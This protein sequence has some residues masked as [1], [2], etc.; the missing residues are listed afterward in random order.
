MTRL[1]V[2]FIV[3][4]LGLIT[5]VASAIP[6]KVSATGS[7]IQV[8]TPD[9]FGTSVGDEFALEARFDSSALVDIDSMFGISVPGVEFASLATS[10]DAS[11][12]IT[13]GSRSWDARSEPFFGSDFFGLFPTPLPH[14]VLLD[15]AFFGLNFFGIGPS[16]DVFLSDSTGQ[17]YFGSTPGEVLG[18]NSDPGSPPFWVGMWDL[19][20]A[21]VVFVPEPGTYFLT[22]LGLA[23]I[24]WNR[25]RRSGGRNIPVSSTNVVRRS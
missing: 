3:V 24:N 10:P 15:G 1:R 4:V 9:A 18:G 6:V 17:L 20:N 21:T 16:D 12:L 19:A 14:V 22:L 23:A 5:K 25:R 11:L 8:L 2:L 7:V 13:L